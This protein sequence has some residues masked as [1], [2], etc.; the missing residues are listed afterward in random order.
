MSIKLSD[1]RD[2][3]IAKFLETAD[4]HPLAYASED[5][6]TGVGSAAVKEMSPMKEQKA[7]SRVRRAII[8]I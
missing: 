2:K 7:Q 1:V 5:R 4:V 6:Q 8:K 3:A